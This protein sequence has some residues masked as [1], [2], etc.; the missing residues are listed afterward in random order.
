MTDKEIVGL[1]W[2]REEK[3]IEQT[4]LKYEIYLMKMSY[5]ILNDKED[6]Q[7]A[8][9]DTYLAAWNSMPE[10]RP[11]NLK[12]YLGTIIRRISIDFFRKR[13][14]RKRSDSEF[15]LSYEELGD[16]LSDN[17]MPDQEFEAK[18]LALEIQTFLMKLKKK[19]RVAFVRR[20]YYSDPMKE[21]AEG[22]KMTEGSMKTMLF[23]IRQ[24]LRQHLC[25]KGYDI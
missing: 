12:L 18:E 6:S 8:V 13:I 7:E 24:R 17:Q 2:A 9:N 21:I 25:E 14:S 15:A 20:Y 10:N 5:N 1:Y 11:D 16:C 19:E 22:F 3:A 4:K 23:R